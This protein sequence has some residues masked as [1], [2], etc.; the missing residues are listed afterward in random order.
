MKEVEEKIKEYNISDRVKMLGFVSDI[1]SLLSITDLQ[2][3][4][5]YATEATSLSL[6]EGMSIGLPTVASDYGGNPFIV[7]EDFNGYIFPQKNSKAMADAI[8]KII[9]NPDLAKEMGENA[10]KLYQ[11]EFTGEIFAGNIEKVYYNL[12]EGAKK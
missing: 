12:I 8:E 3:N 11:T 10:K 1:P 4:A 9:K 7:R 6:L 5:S 2:L